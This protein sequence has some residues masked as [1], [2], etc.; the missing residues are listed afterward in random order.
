MA[1]RLSLAFLLAVSASTLGAGSALGAAV[2]L[3]LTKGERHVFAAGFVH[4]GRKITCTSDGIYIAARV[5]VRG[6]A[7]AKIADGS[8]SSATLSLKTLA[9]GRVIASCS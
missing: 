7:V 6:H 4:V 3:H 8:H 5:P 2:A 9:D 1:G